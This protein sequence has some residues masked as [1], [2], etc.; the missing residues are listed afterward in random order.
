MARRLAKQKRF[1]VRAPKGPLYPNGWPANL[2]A[3]IYLQSK[4]REA[5]QAENWG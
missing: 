3:T 4:A 2:R 5:R 1:G